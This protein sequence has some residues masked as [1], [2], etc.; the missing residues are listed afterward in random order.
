MK[1]MKD[2]GVSVELF[3]YA[4]KAHKLFERTRT[5]PHF[6]SYLIHSSRFFQEAGWLP[7]RPLPP[8]PPV[9]YTHLKV[10]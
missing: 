2:A 9:E 8:L 4:G 3:T 6:Q 7:E 1:R 5:D 10:P